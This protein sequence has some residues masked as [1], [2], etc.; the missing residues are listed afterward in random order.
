MLAE[1]IGGW[2]AAGFM[3]LGAI[4]TTL[5]ALGALYSAAKGKRSLTMGL[6]TPAILMSLM[7]TWYLADAYFH[8]TFHD[9]EEIKLNYVEPWLLMALAPLAVSAIAWTILVWRKKCKQPVPGMP[10]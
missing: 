5:M 3:F 1:D 9:P 6:I 8:R 10:G 2:L 7:V 4:A